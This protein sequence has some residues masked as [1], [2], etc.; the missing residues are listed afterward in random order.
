[1]AENY[2]PIFWVDLNFMS[3]RY[4][5]SLVVLVSCFQNKKALV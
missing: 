4:M 2:S 1:M 5:E 3:I